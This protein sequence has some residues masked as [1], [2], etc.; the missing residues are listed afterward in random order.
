MI[1]YITLGTND[2]DRAAK[3]YDL[4]LAEFGAKRIMETDRFIVWGTRPTRRR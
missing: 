3:F 4:L 1:G 2:I